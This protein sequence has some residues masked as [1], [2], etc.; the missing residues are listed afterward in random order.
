MIFVIEGLDRTG[1]TTLA[2]QLADTHGLPYRHFSKPEQHPLDEY[3]RPIEQLTDAVFD[4]Y[5]WGEVVWP[6]IFNRATDLDEAMFEYVELLLEARGAVTIYS[7]RS[8]AAIAEACARDGEPLLPADIERTM[9]IFDAVHVGRSRVSYRWDLGVGFTS[10]YGEPVETWEVIQVAQRR[11]ERARLAGHSTPRWIGYQRPN[12]LLVGDEVGPGSQGW[13]IPFVPYRGTSGH[14]LMDELRHTGL[15]PAIVNSRAP[16]GA[17]EDVT[18]LWEVLGRP[19]IVAL[20]RRAEAVLTRMGG[21]LFDSVPHPQWWR[22]FNHK[23]GAGSY[24][25][26]IRE[27][28]NA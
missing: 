23:A 2:R 22:R 5:H 25:E 7:E 20:G 1:K 28:A 4:R 14:F 19:P 16:S 9:A 27:A 8:A 6:I 21:L 12:V 17:W 18:G 13:Q 24:G 11:E 26:V 10:R 15:Q 3:C